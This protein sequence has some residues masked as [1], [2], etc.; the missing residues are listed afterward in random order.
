[1][2]TCTQCHATIPPDAS[3][4][5]E[6][7]TRAETTPAAQD[8]STDATREQPIPQ[9]PRATD[10]PAPSDQRATRPVPE[11]PFVEIDPLA[12][13]PVLRWLKSRLAAFIALWVLG[14][15]A[16][17]IVFGIAGISQAVDRAAD[18]FDLGYG[19]AEE[20]GTPGL[21]KAW[22]WLGFLWSLALVIAYLAARLHARIS[23]VSMH[24]PGAGSSSEA[25]MTH[26]DALLRSE[27]PPFAYRAISVTPSGQ[28]SHA[29]LETKD[30][31][32]TGLVTAV[33]HGDDLYVCSNTWVSLTPWTWLWMHLIRAVR[34]L[35][36]IG[37]HGQAAEDSARAMSAALHHAAHEGVAVA[38]GQVQGTRNPS[39]LPP[40][41]AERI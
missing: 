10:P 37:P 11:V 15:T 34:N 41:V 32:Y 24:V 17:F 13:P 39:P 21:L 5:V 20:S 35:R 2:T 40:I 7:G 36:G 31:R 9:S 18:A 19:Y 28:G 22:W 29:Y 14:E 33:A 30:H 6:C 27:R 1:M 25:V 8:P 12:S 26:L 4:C 16:L 3:F 23:E 38:R